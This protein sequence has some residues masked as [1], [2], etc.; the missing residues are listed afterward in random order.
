MSL[1]FVR[2]F[3]YAGAA[4]CALAAPAYAQPRQA[5][6]ITYANRASSGVQTASLEPR[7]AGGGEG[8][9][10]Y[11]SAAPSS[12]PPVDL[13]RPASGQAEQGAAPWLERERVGP[14]YEVGGRWYAPAP[15]PGY[16]MEG[17]ASWYGPTFHGQATASGEIFD[18]EAL[19]AAHPT[20]PIPSLVQVTNL[21]NGRE[22]IVRVNDRGPFVGER[23]IDLSHGAAT[24]LGFD[25][26]GQ[27]RVHVR[28]LGPA[29]RHV[30]SQGAR[31]VVAAAPQAAP[32]QPS[33]GPTSLLPPP[34]A[35]PAPASAEA[36]L[37]AVQPASYSQ[38]TPARGG[39][40]VQ[41]GAFSD[42]MN[43]HRVKAAIETAGPVVVEAAETRQGEIFR[44][45]VGPLAS[46][47]EADAARR[48][49]ADLGF[50]ETI[51]A[52]R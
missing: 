27:A 26:A 41:V 7:L 46:A 21:E 13:R 39:Y 12:G 16:E 6:P 14:P 32:Q 30:A 31:P 17:Q 47:A 9:Y 8:S 22:I 18:Q 36:P 44:V 20:L 1:S 38:P 50:A 45:R 48:A 3:A 52:T 33:S 35:A 23:L 49:L 25:Q 19:T 11:G 10:G 51:V 4:L 37:P 15:E 24:V 43:A 42:L 40:F 2:C 34:S 5:A 28:Y 29:P